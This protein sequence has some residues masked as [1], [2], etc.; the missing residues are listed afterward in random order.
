MTAAT[1]PALAGFADDDLVRELRARGRLVFTLG[2][3][4][5]A[6]LIVEDTALHVLDGDRSAQAMA[7]ALRRM[8]DGLMESLEGHADEHLIAAWGG[9]VRGEVV[10]EFGL[11]DAPAA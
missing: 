7:S 2:P 6:G 9:E 3:R 10:A 4:D 8:S 11:A 5:V 1:D